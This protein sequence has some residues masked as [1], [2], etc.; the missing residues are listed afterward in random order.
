MGS[1]A[2]SRGIGGFWSRLSSSLPPNLESGEVV[3]TDAGA[4]A[5][6]SVRWDL[7]RG[8]RDEAIDGREAEHWVLTVNASGRKMLDEDTADPFE[9]TGRADLWF[10]PALPFSAVPFAVA[11]GSGFPLATM[12]PGA[13]RFALREALPE[14]R[15]RGL[16]LRAEISSTQRHYM[17]GMDE[18]FTSGP[19]ATVLTVSDIRPDG[20][21]HEGSDAPEDRSARESTLDRYVQLGA[22][23][24]DALTMSEHLFSACPIA[25]GAMP[26]ASSARGTVA[27]TPIEAGA[28]SS[29]AFGDD[30][31]M[32]IVVTN[33]E[34]GTPELFFLVAVAPRSA[35]AGSYQAIVPDME[36]LRS[37]AP[38]AGRA[39][40]AV[41]G[42]NMETGA[43][44]MLVAESGSLVLENLAA[45]RTEG[46]IILRG[47]M[48]GRT[49]DAEEAAGAMT[50]LSENSEVE[51]SFVALPDG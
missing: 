39:W 37:G 22:E 32:C 25:G 31:T 29:G 12:D 43:R 27:G 3:H 26:E 23:R 34:A 42:E 21:P 10:D 5:Y 11:R 24:A 47:W 44:S 1:R 35:G 33:F 8:E 46:S 51:I 16:L 9:S 18:P 20:S 2:R 30:E 40:V 14:L 48:V 4:S 36:A 19:D 50:T 17:E 41:M 6:D 28:V 49:P 45:D 38:Q 13:A 15:E 7:T